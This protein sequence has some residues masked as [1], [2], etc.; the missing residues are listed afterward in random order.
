M[1]TGNKIMWK[2]HYFIYIFLTS[3]V[4]LHIRLL[5]VVVQFI[6]FLHSLNSNMS[7]YGYL[8][9]FQWVLGIRDN[10]SRLYTGSLL[11]IYESGHVHCYKDLGGLVGCASDWWSRAHRFDPH[12]VW[13]HSFV[14]INHEIFSTVSLSLS[15]IREE[16]LSVSGERMCTSTG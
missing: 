8:E 6:F 9:V 7:K 2:R 4:K 11:Q 3:G 14:V 13:Q 10:G 12:Q 15:L 1:T 16:Q 5:N